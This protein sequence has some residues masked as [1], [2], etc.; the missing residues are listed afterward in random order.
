MQTRTHVTLPPEEAYRR[1]TGNEPGELIDVRAPAEFAAQHARGARSVP[2]DTL[3]P[4]IQSQGAEKTRP[5]YVL[6]QTGKR[7]AMAAEK[8]AA[9][10]CVNA[11]V[12]E[13]GTVG[14]AAAGLPCES[15]GPK[16]ISLERQVRIGA[17][18]FVLAGVLL[19]WFVHPLFL[20]IA[21]LVGAGL[22]FAGITDWCGMGL[23][24]AKCPWNR[25]G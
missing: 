8:L 11:A 18:A 21:G 2:L 10:G 20:A 16:V 9:A 15:T 25:R 6:C 14:W 22:M 12:I 1:L 3:D 13:G 4:F 24:L 19:G 5:I 23:L 7:A 17:G